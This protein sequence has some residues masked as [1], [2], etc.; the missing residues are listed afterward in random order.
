MGRSNID[1]TTLFQQVSECRSSGLTDKNWCLEHGIALS[2]FYLW[3]KKL[4]DSASFEI[5]ESEA[6]GDS[7]SFSLRQDVVNVNVIPDHPRSSSH[8]QITHSYPTK[9]EEAPITITLDSIQIRIQNSADPTLVADTLRML[10][11]F[12]C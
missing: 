6:S 3:L 5:P 7:S 9:T 8:Q 12:L 10:R 1:L 2:T 11:G 4:R